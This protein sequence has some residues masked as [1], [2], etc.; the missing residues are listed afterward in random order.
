ME[1]NH[2]AVTTP[3]RPAA[4]VAL[5]RDGDQGL[6]VLLMKRHGDSDVLGGAHVFPGG[7]VDREDGDDELLARIDEPALTLWQR[8][9]EAD[10]DTPEAAAVFVAALRELFEEAG[11]LLAAPTPSPHLT[12]QVAGLLRSGHRFIEALALCGVTLSARQIVPWTRWITPRTPSVSRKRFDTRFFLAAL[13]P[14]QQARADEHEAVEIA[15]LRPREALRRYHERSIDLAPPQ[16][17]SLIHLREY[18]SVDVALREAS[19]RPVALIE[20]APFD[21]EGTRVMAYPGDER[22][23]VREARMPG[24]SRLTFRGGRF[25]PPGGF[26]PLIDDGRSA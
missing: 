7:K 18:P 20:P 3:V 19:A 21:D 8:L 5:L 1:L 23:P 4:T 25:Y 16:I 24:P 12:T 15:W 6:E 13:P 26:E 14:G 9:G 17:M 22:H 10:L 2:E 11:V